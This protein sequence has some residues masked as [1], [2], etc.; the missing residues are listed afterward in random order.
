M[1]GKKFEYDLRMMIWGV[2][3]SFLAMLGI[4]FYPSSIKIDF[5]FAILFW[6]GV[7][8][9]II[10]LLKTSQERKQLEKDRNKEYIADL[11]IGILSFFQNK[12]GA[13]ADTI[14]FLVVCAFVVSEWV[15]YHLFRLVFVALS[16][17]FFQLHCI[18]NGRNYQF[19][20]ILKSKKRG[21]KDEE[22]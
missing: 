1:Q 6:S 16:Y 14:L 11:P 2:M 17:G 5:L 19:Y 22:V 8:L 10:F 3:V 21:T 9:E 13:F 12:R 7:F 4:A 15:D 20:R 18:W